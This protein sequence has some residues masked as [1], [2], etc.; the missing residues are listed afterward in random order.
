M[1]G[2]G[3]AD[4]LTYTWSVKS[5]PAARPARRSRS[6]APKDTQVHVSMAGEYVLEVRVYNTQSHL[7]TKAESPSI[8]GP[9]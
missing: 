7:A 2:T 6:T 1:P 3:V 5:V 9:R 8:P 4:D